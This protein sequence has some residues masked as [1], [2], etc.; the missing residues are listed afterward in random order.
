MLRKEVFAFFVHNVVRSKNLQTNKFTSLSQKTNRLPK[1][2]I[3]F[4]SAI[5]NY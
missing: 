2:F 5:L 3:I 1:N 4:A